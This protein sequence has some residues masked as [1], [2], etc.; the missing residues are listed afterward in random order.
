MDCDSL[1][2][3][4]ERRQQCNATV[5][6]IPMRRPF[7]TLGWLFDTDVKT[8]KRQ[9]NATLEKLTGSPI[10]LENVSVSLITGGKGANP[11][12]VLRYLVKLVDVAIDVARSPQHLRVFVVGS[13]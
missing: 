4:L 2:K 10:H 8:T 7:V 5:V 12:R 3:Q 9:V 6:G 1:R 13:Y 11:K